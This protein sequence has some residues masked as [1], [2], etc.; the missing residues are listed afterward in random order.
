MLVVGGEGEDGVAPELLAG[1]GGALDHGALLNAQPVEARR[2]ERLDRRRE[3]EQR[4]LVCA[5]RDHRGHLLGVERVSVRG[6]RN[7]FL[8]L[9]ARAEAIEQLQRV[10]PRERRQGQRRFSAAPAQPRRPRVQELGP[11]DAEDEDR[12]ITDPA[13]EVFDEVEHRRLRP[14]HV[15]E[16]EDERPVVR[17]RFA[18]LA[19]GPVRLLRPGRPAAR[20]RSGQPLDD[21]LA[22]IWICDQPR[23][24]R[25]AAEVAQHLVDR[26]ERDAVAVGEAPA[27]EHGRALANLVEQLGHQPRLADSCRSE[28]REQR[29]RPLGDGALVGPA[30]PRKL[31]VASDERRV[32]SPRDRRQAGNCGKDAPRRHRRALSLRDDRLCGLE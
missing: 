12:R 17:K 22:F 13:G 11:R 18:D 10:R 21:E 23:N 3:R 9:A 4:V 31:V 32:R 26:P 24:A 5:F 16:A 30:Q 28:E 29:A 14:V 1:D 27:D 19:E 20:R 8:R 2:E 25:V 15:L 6:L 7:P